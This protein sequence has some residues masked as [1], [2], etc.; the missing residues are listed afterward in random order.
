MS[1]I[2]VLGGGLAGLVA[3]TLLSRKGFRVKLIERKPYPFHRVCGE[4]ISNEVKPF[5]KANDLYPEEVAPAN[6]TQFELTSINGKRAQMP[7]DLGG[8]GVSRYYLDHYLARKA[9]EAGVELVQEKVSNLKFN[10][11]VFQISSVKSSLET[12]VVVGAFGKRSNVDKA[13][14]RKFINKRSPYLGVKYHI[15][16]EGHDGGTVALH[17]FQGGYC[18]IN[19][20]ENETFN[21]CYLSERANVRKWGSIERMEKEVVQKN[22]F[23]KDIFSTAYFLFEKPEV[24][25]EISFE[26]KHPVEDHVLMCGDAAGMITPLCGNGMAIAVHSAKIVAEVIGKHFN[27]DNL[28]RRAMEQEYSQQWNDMF[29]RRLWIGRKIQ[30]MF[31]AAWLSNAAVGICNNIPPLAHYLMSKTHGKPIDS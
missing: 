8:F 29:R 5:L 1:S 27:G 3:S 26:T 2:A 23:L 14:D 22:P 7:L 16:Y 4:Y 19:R 13:M 24:I 25:N 31:G 6:I 18:G 11:N 12:Q 28:N 21:L 10:G 15:K 20:V 17:N 30:N 9:V